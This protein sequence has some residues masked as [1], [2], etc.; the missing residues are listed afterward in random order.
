[1]TVSMPIGYLDHVAFCVSD[2]EAQVAW[3]KQAFGL[4]EG[5]GERIY[6]EEP[7]TQSALLM[8]SDNG[9]CIEIFERPGSERPPSSGDGPLEGT[10]DQG[11]H[12]WTLRV[13]DLDATLAHLEAVGAKVLGFRG[14]YP[15]IGARIAFVTDPEGNRL[16]LVQPIPV[17]GAEPQP[18]SLARMRH[19]Q[20]TTLSTE[21][22]EK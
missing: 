9:L 16:E 6:T 3:Y 12:H 19:D 18:G 7:W 21:E 20:A 2:F 4:H 15:H 13:E 1:M 11:F 14:D 8:S 17:V 5:E 10:R 22:R